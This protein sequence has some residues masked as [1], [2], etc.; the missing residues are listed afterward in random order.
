MVHFSTDSTL[1]VR[2][3]QAT[4]ILVMLNPVL[5]KEKPISLLR[6]LQVVCGLRRYRRRRCGCGRCSG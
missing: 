2:T 1:G 6:V 4:K 3:P 5:L